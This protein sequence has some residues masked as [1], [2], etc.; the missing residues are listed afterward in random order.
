M[1]MG[2]D[3]DGDGGEGDGGEGDGGEGDG[4]EGD[5]RRWWGVVSVE[6]G[7]G[8]LRC[9]T[10]WEVPVGSPKELHSFPLSPNFLNLDLCHFPPPSSPPPSTPPPPPP[11]RCS[12]IAIAAAPIATSIALTTIALSSA[13]LPSISRPGAVR[14]LFQHPQTLSFHPSKTVSPKG[15][16]FAVGTLKGEKVN[17]LEALVKHTNDQVFSTT[18]CFFV[19]ILLLY[20][21]S[22]RSFL[23][24]YTF[25]EYVK[26]VSS[27][28]THPDFLAHPVHKEW[29]G[30][31]TNDTHVCE[32]LYKA[33]MYNEGH[34]K[35]MPFQCIYHSPGSLLL[36]I[37]T[38][39]LYA[40]RS[41]RKPGAQSVSSP[42]PSPSL[43]SL[44]SNGG[45]A[46]SQVNAKRV[47]KASASGPAASNSNP[48][49]G[50][51]KWHDIELPEM[52]SQLS[53]WCNALQA[54]DKDPNRVKVRL[55]DHGYRFPE[56]PLL[57][58]CSEPTW[59]KI[60]LANWLAVRPMWMSQVDHNPPTSF[61]SPQL[62]HD[63]L[64]SILSDTELTEAAAQRVQEGKSATKMGKRKQAA[65][66]LFGENI[67]VTTGRLSSWVVG[68]TTFFNHFGRPPVVPHAYPFG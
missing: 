1:E 35:V 3:G 5:G 48:K 36:H 9:E 12:A 21:T 22:Q 30:A 57:I 47:Q 31:F 14:N 67:L 19:A 41:D 54:V 8:K 16:A 34:C 29:M 58:T 59:K 23:N 24:I 43:P 25:M 37:N 27:H 53:I 50:H 13:L 65:W 52:P 7:G 32:E 18:S 45:K 40:R 15:S 4:G 63:F 62:W 61:P 6:N 66:E 51:N 68:G 10:S 38:R 64:N 33:A 2:V 42:V 39:C 11:P 56:P 26:T 20:V 60:F 28:I 17:G 46:A 55:V 49:S 44:S